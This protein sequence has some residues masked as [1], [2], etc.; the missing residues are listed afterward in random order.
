MKRDWKPAH[1]GLDAPIRDCRVF[2]RQKIE[3]LID[4]LCHL[5][6][7][8]FVPIS[9]YGKKCG[10]GNG[11]DLLFLAGI[12]AGRNNIPEAGID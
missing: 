3:I 10:L 7:R 12:C 2:F 1:S 11:F 5:T 8:F 6:D 4:G 9:P